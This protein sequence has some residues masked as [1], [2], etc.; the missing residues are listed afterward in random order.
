MIFYGILMGFYGIVSMDLGITGWW[1]EKL[2]LETGFPHQIVGL[3]VLPSGKLT[4]CYWK[5]QLIVYLPIKNGDFPGL[6]KRLPECNFPWDQS[7][8]IWMFF[9]SEVKWYWQRKAVSKHPGDGSL[10]PDSLIFRFLGHPGSSSW[11]NPCPFSMLFP[12]LF[13]HRCWDIPQ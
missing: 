12:W 13:P 1:R 10:S 3:A 4:V 9:F 2:P 6:C 7:N 11:V 5:W 8:E